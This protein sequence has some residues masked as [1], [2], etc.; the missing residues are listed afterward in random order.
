MNDLDDV[1]P[2]NINLFEANIFVYRALNNFYLFK[3]ETPKLQDSHFSD[4]ELKS[5]LMDYNT[6]EDLFSEL[7]YANDRFSV[8]YDDYRKLEKLLDGVNLSTGA[9]FSFFNNDNNGQSYLIVR[10]IIPHSDADKEGVVRGDIFYE[11]NGQAISESTINELLK[12]PVLELKYAYIEGDSIAHSNNSVSLLNSEIEEPAIGMYSIITDDNNSKIAYLLYNRFSS[13]SISELNEIFREFKNEN[14]QDLVL[15]LRYN[16]GGSVDAAEA[17][18]NLITG[19][20]TGK[21]MYED[22]WNSDINPILGKKVNFKDKMSNGNAYNSLNLNRLAVLTQTGTA[23]ASE[24]VI[25]AL[26]PYIDLVQI[27]TATRGK[28]QGS[29]LLYD[30]PNFSANHK[31]IN[32]R[33][34]MLPLVMKTKN[35]VGYTDFDEGLTPTH[36]AQEY[37]EDIKNN[38]GEKSEKLLSI[39]LNKFNYISIESKAIKQKH[40]ETEVYQI[41]TPKDNIMYKRLEYK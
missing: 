15:D 3:D 8:L 10:Q 13:A 39:A 34:A 36:E 23:S 21:L 12:A 7:K 14:V 9:I 11:V 37:V 17:L 5:F 16:S 40:S 2:E 1:L 6:P 25:N 31:N 32:H 19:Q 20:L 29:V 28:Y 38:L 30:S 41:A 27:G 18:C 4:E 35:S 26:N 24:L 33:Y 22:E